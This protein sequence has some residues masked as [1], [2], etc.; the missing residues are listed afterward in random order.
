MDE[1]ALRR[2]GGDEVTIQA[3]EILAREFVREDAGQDLVEYALLAGLVAVGAGAVIP[4]MAPS[5]YQ[6]FS[7]AISVLERFS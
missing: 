1:Q 2:A 7:K 3:I 6:I 5:V 4:P